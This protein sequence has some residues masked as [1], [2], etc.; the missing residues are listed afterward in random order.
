[1]W[2]SRDTTHLP[3]EVCHG[4]S[5]NDYVFTNPDTDKPF[6][7]IKRPFHTACRL[8][9]VS[10]TLVACMTTRNLL[11]SVGA[12]S[13]RS[14]HDQ[15]EQHNSK[16]NGW[17]WGMMSRWYELVCAALDS[18]P[19][20]LCQPGFWECYAVRPTVYIPANTIHKVETGS[21]Q[22]THRICWPDATALVA[23][24]RRIFRRQNL[25]QKP[26]RFLLRES[27]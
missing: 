13:L 18:Y 9:G 10:R 19:A 4:K 11:Y 6:Y 23:Q 2:S 22:M 3:R 25:A 27:H 5:V 20:A 12:C 7:D 15:L 26:A 14:T 1:V 24:L 16:L 21:H 17:R 8:A